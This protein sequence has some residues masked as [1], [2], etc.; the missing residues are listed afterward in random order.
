M[1]DKP[2]SDLRRR[3]IA[4]TTI[5]TFIDKTQRDYIQQPDAYGRR[6]IA[7][8]LPKLS[9]KSRQGGWQVRPKPLTVRPLHITIRA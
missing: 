1:S 9:G 7:A 5:R 2:I 6:R 3:M 8:V 4:D